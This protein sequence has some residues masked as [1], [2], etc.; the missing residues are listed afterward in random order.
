ML[1]FIFWLAAADWIYVASFGNEPV[2]SAA[3]F[4][5]ELLTTSLRWKLIVLGK[6]S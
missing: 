2:A 4:L 5:G 6:G 3:D 1:I